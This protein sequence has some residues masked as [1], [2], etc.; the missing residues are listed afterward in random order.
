MQTSY[1]INY[2]D[3]NYFAALT[4]LVTWKTPRFLKLLLCLLPT[5]LFTLQRGF[6][7]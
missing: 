6:I 5:A 3:L 7:L 2:R 1:F 4:A